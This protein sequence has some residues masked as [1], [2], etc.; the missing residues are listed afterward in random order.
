MNKTLLKGLSLQENSNFLE[1]K[2]I[3]SSFVNSEN[4]EERIFALTNL[5]NIFFIEKNYNQ[6]SR[7][8][9]YAI[10][11]D[12]KNQKAY[13]NYGVLKLRLKEYE[14]AKKLFI[15]SIN[16]NRNH[17]SSNLNLAIVLKN[18]KEYDIS[19]KYFDI[20]KNLKSKD[21]DYYY[22]IANLYLAM[23]KYFLALLNYKKSIKLNPQ[24]PKAYY[25]IAL[26]FH[27]THRDKTAIN[28]FDKAIELKNNYYDAL[29]AKGLSLLQLGDYQNGWELY[30]Y[31]YEA[32]NALKRVDYKIPEYNGQDLK[33]KTILVQGEQGFGD[34]IEFCRY[35]IY[36]KNAKKVYFA[37]RE[38]LVK[39]MTCSFK[40][41][42]IKVVGDKDTLYNIDYYSSLLDLPRVYKNKD[43]FL[44]T[45]FPYLKYEK[46]EFDIQSLKNN[47]T[48]I[49]FVWKG[50]SEHKND[51]NRSID[52]KEFETLFKITH[53][54]F[55]S[56]QIDE[57]EALDDYIHKYENIYDLSTYIKDFNDTSN[58]LLKMD[59]LIS[60]DSS[61]IHL[62]GALNIKS[63]LILP[64]FYEWRWQN[65]TNVSWYNNFFYEIQKK[66]K[67]WKLPINNI[68]NS[69]TNDYL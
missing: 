2:E 42:N 17:Y 53:I 22:N 16:L 40:N 67:D 14:E 4:K 54:D 41:T 5:A 20:V 56:F 10:K 59:C 63:Y 64:K 30:K 33:N 31:R 66:Q 43:I 61:M 48:K 38:P 26:V 44:D 32:N 69:L 60:I 13:Y 8:Y 45:K 68:K 50:N 23:E 39:L 36:L 28:Y 51:H 15:S 25:S 46:K 3:Y 65:N 49:G 6:A 1:A 9:E 57:K 21:M 58:L 7:M 11:I 27:K 12:P 52:I 19:K 35:L 62:A 29:F 37:V 24:N 55:Y 34:N 47:K 18:L